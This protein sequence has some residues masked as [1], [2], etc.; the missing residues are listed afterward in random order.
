M[1]FWVTDVRGPMVVLR[2][3]QYGDRYLAMPRNCCRPAL[4]LSLGMVVIAA[5]LSGSAFIPCFVMM[6]PI[7]LTSGS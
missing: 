2:L 6:L 5:T 4:F 3:G 1:S 7:N